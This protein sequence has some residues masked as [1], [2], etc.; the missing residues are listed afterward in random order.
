M[1]KP[2]LANEQIIVQ[3]ATVYFNGCKRIGYKGNL[4][5]IK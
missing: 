1:K 2:K 4:S 5:G 3:R